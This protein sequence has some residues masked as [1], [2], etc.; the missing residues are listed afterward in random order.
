LCHPGVSSALRQAIQNR[1]I[2]REVIQELGHGAEPLAAGRA[3]PAVSG[4]PLKPKSF[5]LDHRDVFFH[6]NPVLPAVAFYGRINHVV[7]GIDASCS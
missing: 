5:G 7:C 6:L 2:V 4:N 1:N 3:P